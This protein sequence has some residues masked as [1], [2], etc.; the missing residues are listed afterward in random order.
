MGARAFRVGRLSNPRDELQRAIQ[1]A[2]RGVAAASAEGFRE[3][4]Q[5][6]RQAVLD[7]ERLVL[8]LDQLI[9]QGLRRRQSSDRVSS[10]EVEAAIDAVRRA[11]G[12]LSR[13]TPLQLSAV[14]GQ[15]TERVDVLLAVAR[16]ILDRG[17]DPPVNV[18]EL[19]EWKPFRER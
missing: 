12:S 17:L 14:Y 8:V 13:T 11:V 10:S 3:V 19:D 16:S 7:S 4:L 9:R 6:V 15:Y 2:E 18:R 1:R 5:R